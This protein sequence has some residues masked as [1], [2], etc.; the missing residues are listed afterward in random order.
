M[1]LLLTKKV[2]WKAKDFA[3]ILSNRSFYFENSGTAI[4]KEHLSVAVSV[5]KNFHRNLNS[6]V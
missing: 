5:A 6:N 2:Q 1:L 3:K 4:F